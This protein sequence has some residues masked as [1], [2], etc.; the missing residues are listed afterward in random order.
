LTLPKVSFK[1]PL[2]TIN[3]PQEVLLDSPLYLSYLFNFQKKLVS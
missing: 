3:N 2:T 1:L